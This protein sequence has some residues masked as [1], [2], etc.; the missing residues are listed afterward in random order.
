MSRSHRQFECFL[1]SETKQKM[2]REKP[3]NY[4]SKHHKKNKHLLELVP[5]QPPHHKKYR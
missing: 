4:N 1:C 5:R 3:I 2:Y